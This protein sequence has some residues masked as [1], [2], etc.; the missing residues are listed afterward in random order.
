M[1]TVSVDLFREN[2]LIDVAE[3]HYPCVLG[4]GGLF[5]NNFGNNR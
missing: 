5:R 3:D 1:M 4:L 2:D